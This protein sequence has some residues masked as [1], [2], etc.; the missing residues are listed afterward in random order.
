MLSQPLSSAGYK[1]HIDKSVFFGVA[2]NPAFTYNVDGSLA[3]ITY[4]SNGATKI[5]TYSDG[6]LTQIDSTLRG[7]AARKTFSYTDGVLTS[8]TQVTL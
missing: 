8:I 1:Q 2:T 5:M 4:G 7:V 3:Q 6:Y